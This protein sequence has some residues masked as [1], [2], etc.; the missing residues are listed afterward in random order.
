M[1]RGTAFALVAFA[2]AVS[3]AAASSGRWSHQGE[4]MSVSTADDAVRACSD[5]TVR[6]DGRDAARAE[7]T[8]RR[9]AAIR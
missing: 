6:W 1:L 3:P 2:A 8:S 9:W 5:I 7:E 4:N